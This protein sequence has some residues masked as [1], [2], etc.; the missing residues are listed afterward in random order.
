MRM[1]LTTQ[2]TEAPSRYTR[3]IPVALTL[4][5]SYGLLGEY[6]Y[7]TDSSSLIRLLSSATDLATPDLRRFEKDVFSTGVARLSG[8]NVKDSVLETIGYFID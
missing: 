2:P 4:K 7:A 6:V 8:V 1:N 3:N 5:P